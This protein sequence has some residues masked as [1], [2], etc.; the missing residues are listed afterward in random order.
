MNPPS[1]PRSGVA[2]LPQVEAL[3]QQWLAESAGAGGARTGRQ[4]AALLQ[5]PDGLSFAVGFID[6]VIR[7][8]DR[9]AAASNLAE[10]AHRAPAFLPWY[11]RAAVRLGGRLGPVVPGLVIPIARR[12]L[13]QVVGHLLID[14]SDV[15]L[16]RAL[17]RFRRRG[18]SINLNLLGEAV[19]GRTEA[20]RRLDHTRRLLAREDVSYVSLKVSAAIAPHSPWAF[21]E[22]VEE[23]VATLLPV[24]RRAA[25]EATFLNLDMEEYRDLGVTLAVFTRLLDH[26]DLLEYEAGIVLQAYLPDA[27]P[28]MIRLQEWSRAR[29]E[30]G[31]A[32]IKVRLVKGANLPMERVDASLYGW[33]L[34]TWPTKQQTD[35]HYK[36][37]LDYALHPDR[38]RNVRLGVAGHNLFDVAY[39]WILAGER[40]ARDGIDIEM[41][42]GMAE[43]QA[44]AVRRT[45]GRL[46][47][48]VPVVHP[49][50]FDVAIAYLVRRLEEGASRENFMSAVVGLAHDPVL[51][52][53]ERDRF[54][55]SLA[56]VDAD[57]ALPNRR[58]D[59][60]RDVVAMVGP[61]EFG[62]APDT[63]PAL[64]ANRAWARAITAR[65][66]GSTLGHE[67]VDQHTVTSAADLEAVLADSDATKA[68]SAR[69]APARADILRRAARA[70]E[71]AR[72][73]LLEVMAAECGKTLEQ[74]DPEVSEAIDFA[75]YYALLAEQLDGI[76]GARAVP[77]GLTVV[78]PPWNFPVAILAG[79]VLGALAAGSRVIVKPAPQARR[80]GSLVVNALWS[81]GVPRAALALVHVGEGE[82][83][84]TLISDPR[85]DR[86]ILTGGFATA[87][88]FRSFRPDLGL[89]AETSGKNALIVTPQADLDLAVRDLVASAFGHAGQKCSAASLA[90][91][92]GSV[93]DS[94]R[95][96]T[97]L[98]DAVSSLR[99]GFPDDPR[100]QMGPL[101]EPAGGKLL[102]ALTSLAPGER[103]LV[104]PRQLDDRGRLWTPGVK[105]GIRPGS[106]YHLTEY[107]GPVLGLMR[108]ADLEEAI[109]WANQVPYGLT[110]GLHSLDSGEVDRWAAAVQAG[111]LYVNRST[112]G[113]I[114]RRQPFGGW[115]R[116]A[117]GAG[118]KAGGP[119]YLVG[120]CDWRSEPA[121]R[122]APLGS[123]ATRVLDS[124]RRLGLSADEASVLERSLG[125]DARS[126]V[127]DFGLLRDVSGLPAERNGLRYRPVP[128]IVR[129]EAGSPGQLLRVVAAGLLVGAPVTVSSAVVPAP[130][131]REVLSGLGVTV[132]VQNPATWAEALQQCP[133]TRV[134]LLGGDP[135]T[136]AAAARGRPDIA[137]YAQP[138]VESGRIELLTFLQEQSVSVTAH[139]FGAPSL[140][141]TG[142]DWRGP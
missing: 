119:N 46:L 13:R 12:A 38:L 141:T 115:K 70:L 51:Y 129:D 84:R 93:A 29:R 107:F 32:A 49:K 95:F 4:L 92:V 55:A 19:L 132:A 54:A 20:A 94:R 106:E 88:L 64:P 89:L 67:L 18:V 44:E 136:F 60:T 48:Y 53:R 97:Q 25:V 58:Q 134:R 9:R 127:E 113:A 122:T 23:M 2:L 137:L 108:A 7:P 16:G 72:A 10:L 17:A 71:N 8:E 3:V 80:C 63:D 30:R 96:R 78:T 111:N 52:T 103:W 27:L 35:T 33:P 116:S 109:A 81:A 110:A 22:T 104:T 82:L 140:L 124:A 117:V 138:V 114:V 62:N 1:A 57:I 102:R 75:H 83:S 120:L 139:R 41:L 59:R 79:S 21:D 101:I 90:I 24:Y 50:D 69:S 98:V 42:L 66:G 105:T 61:G 15:H 142:W 87:E 28:A 112:V 131:L 45:V 133:P 56:E 65:I 14:A 11:Q 5:D 76:D 121:T 26:P 99:V 91:L 73:D 6:R 39:A 31:G 126:W 37:V 47:L 77:V 125:S 34:A 43:G 118:A 128:V 86:V 74:G 100:V 123:T 40:R 135:V 85:V 36:R 130:R 68:W